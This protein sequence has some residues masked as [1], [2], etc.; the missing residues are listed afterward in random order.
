[1]SSTISPA[2]WLPSAIVRLAVPAP[3]PAPAPAGPRHL[4]PDA[5]AHRLDA[6]PTETISSRGR[7]AEP[8]WSREVFDHLRDED[9][10]SWL[11][12]SD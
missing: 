10:F 11:G 2:S 4:A 12:F 6:V 8:E 9:P 3:A 7:H 5:D 1:M